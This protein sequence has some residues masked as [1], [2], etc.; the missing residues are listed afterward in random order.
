M[1]KIGSEVR[2]TSPDDLAFSPSEFI[3]IETRAWSVKNWRRLN[4]RGRPRLRLLK[5]AEARGGRKE[6]ES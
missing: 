1:G 4:G 5:D 6:K 2:D 3:I